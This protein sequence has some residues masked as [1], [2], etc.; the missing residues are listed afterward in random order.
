[1]LSQE[2]TS[3]GAGGQVIKTVVVW[4]QGGKEFLDL[5]QK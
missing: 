4:V 5:R 2:P 1:M 3:C